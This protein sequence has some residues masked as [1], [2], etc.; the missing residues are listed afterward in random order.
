[1]IQARA[2][3]HLNSALI[4]GLSQLGDQTAG[5]GNDHGQ[6]VDVER[7]L[8]SPVGHLDDRWRR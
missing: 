7:R 3:T 1:M 4:T 6:H 2:S 8:R 5:T